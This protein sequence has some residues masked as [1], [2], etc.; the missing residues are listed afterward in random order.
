M[1][2]QRTQVLGVPGVRLVHGSRRRA[3]T[4]SGRCTLSVLDRCRTLTRFLASTTSHDAPLL[5][6]SAAFAFFTFTATSHN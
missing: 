1:L 6:A 4:L 5:A 3:Y 2:F